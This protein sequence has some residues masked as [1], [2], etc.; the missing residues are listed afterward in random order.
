MEIMTVGKRKGQYI[1]VARTT[2]GVVHEL[3]YDTFAQ[4]YPDSLLD[5]LERTI[6][7]HHEC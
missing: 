6:L 4:I 3:D 2:D 7:I 5:F 1:V